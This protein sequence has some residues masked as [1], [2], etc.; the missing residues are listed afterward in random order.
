MSKKKAKVVCTCP[1]IEL[2]SFTYEGD[3]VTAVCKGCNGALGTT[4]YAN[5][6]AKVKLF[7]QAQPKPTLEL[8]AIAVLKAVQRELRVG[9]AA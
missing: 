7:R 4:S 6:Q 9:W 8:F 5:P 1:V 3:V 2:P